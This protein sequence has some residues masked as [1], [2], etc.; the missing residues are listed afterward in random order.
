VARGGRLTRRCRCFDE[1]PSALTRDPL[2]APAPQ[3]SRERRRDSRTQG[4]TPIFGSI[5][6]SRGSRLAPRPEAGVGARHAFRR[7]PIATRIGVRGPRRP[8]DLE[9]IPDA[10]CHA[11]DAARPLFRSPSERLHSDPR[12][13][14]YLDFLQLAATTASS[15]RPLMDRSRNASPTR[16]CAELGRV[17]VRIG[18]D[19]PLETRR[20]GRQLRRRPNSRG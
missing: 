13:G 10:H 12:P 5:G 19:A 9:A 3:V 4:R 11:H 1:K 15:T 20:A 18:C 2:V 6:V 17:H 7:A 16:R 8:P 14:P